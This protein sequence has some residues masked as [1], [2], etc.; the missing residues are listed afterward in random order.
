M[1]FGI[2]P[3]DLILALIGRIG[4]AGGTGYAIEYTGEVIRNMSM[5]GRMTI[6]NMSI[7]AGARAGMIA[8]DKTTEAFIK[9]RPYAP[10]GED[11]KQATAYWQSLRSDEGATFDREEHFH[12]AELIPQVTWGTSPE[13]VASIDQ[14]VPE[15]PRDDVKRT[16]VKRALDYMGLKPGQALKGLPIDKVFIGSCTNARMEDLRAV[17][18]LVK[19]QKV[20]R[21]IAQALIVPGSGQIK[22]QA[23]REGLDVIFQKAGFEWRS[24]GCSMC[25]GMNDDRLLPEER[26]A[27]TSNRNFEGRQGK[28]GRTHLM[29]PVMAAAAALTGKLTD[30]REM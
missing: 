20:A 21:T 4:T 3:K 2:T 29:S 6:C 25:L 8:Y 5:E 10:E 11:F 17:A 16:S 1:G 28:G 30:V 18:Q 19:G 12:I 24:A 9:G 14:T 13:M 7:E 26:C 27:S 15:L 23:E 22:L